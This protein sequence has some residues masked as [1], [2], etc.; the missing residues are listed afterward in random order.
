MIAYDF[1]YPWLDQQKKDTFL[2]RMRELIDYVSHEDGFH[3]DFLIPL[4]SR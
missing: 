3:I 1:I 2:A 4:T